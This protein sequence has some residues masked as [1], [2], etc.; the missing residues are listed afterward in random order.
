MA[1]REVSHVEYLRVA[2]FGSRQWLVHAGTGERVS[3][4]PGDWELEFGEDEYEGVG[5]LCCSLPDSEPQVYWANTLLT[6]SLHVVEEE[7]SPPRTVVQQKGGGHRDI[8]DAAF[9]ICPKL[10]QLGS[11][12]GN[13]VDVEI[14][15]HSLMHGQCRGFW[16]MQRLTHFVWPRDKYMQKGFVTRKV[17]LLPRRLVALGL[18]DSTHVR[19]SR[20]GWL[21]S[22][23]T[24]AGSAYAEPAEVEQEWSVNTVT[25]L[26]WLVGLLWSSANPLSVIGANTNESRPLVLI[27]AICCKLFGGNSFVIASTAPAFTMSL[28]ATSVGVTDMEASLQGLLRQD[29]LRMTLPRELTLGALLSKLCFAVTCGK[30]RHG[31]KDRLRVLLATIIKEVGALLDILLEAHMTSDFTDMSVEAGRTGT[32]GLRTSQA[33]KTGMS[34]MARRKASKRGFMQ[35]FGESTAKRRRVVSGA[36]EYI[37]HERASQKQDKVRLY[38]YLC[39]Q[40]Q[41]GSVHTLSLSFDG[42][43]AIGREVVCGVLQWPDTN[44]AV[45]APVQVPW[46]GESKRPGDNNTEGRGERYLLLATRV[47]TIECSPLYSGCFRF[48]VHFSRYS[49]KRVVVALHLPAPPGPSQTRKP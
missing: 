47:I 10:L 39:A 20:L 46:I 15:W 34:A 13:T 4:P 19:Q 41:R 26:G 35:G 5:A 48:R 28:G 9:D 27:D 45:W 33:Y 8:C 3:L 31:A 7:G 40:R 42:V 32:R 6:L 36:P 1:T 30:H 11:I 21:A 12:Q 44:V 24:Q 14:Y 25:M 2:N 17:Q 29:V 23:A 49:V 43:K 16:G 18:Q 22:S 38:G 37:I